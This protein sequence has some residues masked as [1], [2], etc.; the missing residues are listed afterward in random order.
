MQ[1]NRDMKGLPDPGIFLPR[2]SVTDRRFLD[3]ASIALV[4]ADGLRARAKRTGKESSALHRELETVVREIGTL[5]RRLDMA[6]PQD[7]LDRYLFN[8]AALEWMDTLKIHPSSQGGPLRWPQ[9]RRFL[10][11]GEIHEIIL[12]NDNLLKEM[13]CPPSP[14]TTGDWVREARHWQSLHRDWIPVLKE[15]CTQSA[16][17]SG[18][19]EP[20]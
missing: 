17:V 15:Y 12:S 9:P 19:L 4:V 5:L 8:E 10:S 7:T 18:E 13:L 2:I 1:L 20:V 14:M 3:L 11:A 6:P 16:A